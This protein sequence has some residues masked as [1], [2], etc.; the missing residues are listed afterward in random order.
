[1]LSCSRVDG[2]TGRMVHHVPEL[3][4]FR[5]TKVYTEGG[6]LLAPT[7]MFNFYQRRTIDG[8]KVR[9]ATLLGDRPTLPR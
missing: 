2:K 3:W 8:E 9:E 7:E 5:G 6:G 4:L 1:M